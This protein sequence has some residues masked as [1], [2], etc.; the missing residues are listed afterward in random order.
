V[1]ER[2]DHA[3]LPLVSAAGRKFQGRAHFRGM[4][5][6]LEHDIKEVDEVDE[7]YVDTWERFPE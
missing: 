5:T 7:G 4:D 3:L 6:L 1:T 2:E